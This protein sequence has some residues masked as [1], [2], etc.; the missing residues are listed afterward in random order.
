MAF[1]QNILS[2][3]F[4]QLIKYNCFVDQVN[5]MLEIF[6]VKDSISSPELTG[7]LIG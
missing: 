1:Y 6:F 7:E 3:K 4:Q 2:L 5:K